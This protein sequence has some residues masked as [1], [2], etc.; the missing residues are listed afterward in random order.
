[1]VE[2]ATFIVLAIPLSMIGSIM[3]ALA[4]SHFLAVFGIGEGAPFTAR[5]CAR[6]T[7]YRGDT[8]AISFI[9]AITIMGAIALGVFTK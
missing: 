8:G 6:Q 1:M 4:I 7:I 2:T 9:L 5:S 3:I